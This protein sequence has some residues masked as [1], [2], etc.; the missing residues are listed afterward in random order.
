MKFNI[1]LSAFLMLSILT[2]AQSRTEELV[3]P[4][5][6]PN[7]TGTLIVNI[8]SGSI[9]VT[10]TNGKEVLLKATSG[11]VKE[12]DVRERIIVNSNV[13]SK[14]APRSEEEKDEATREAMKK[15]VKIGTTLSETKGLKR[16]LNSSMNITVTEQN[17]VV[18]VSNESPNRTVFLEIQVPKN[19]D[20]K[21][22]T[23][24]H[25]NVT[26]SD[27]NG[28]HE[29][30]NVNGS[31]ILENISG[32]A[33]A[34]TVNGKVKANLLEWNSRNPM[35]F[36]TLNGNV[37]LTLPANAK[38]NVKLDSDR[39]Q[40]YSDFDVNVVKPKVEPGKRSASGIY[41]V[42]VA[43]GVTGSVNGGGPEI[44]MKNMNG[45]IYLRKK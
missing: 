33:I 2:F 25:G 23:V 43:D 15:I 18:Q 17:N 4:L 39:G 6:K 10:G 35:A 42:T 26:V 14:P 7:E 27:V 1:L 32:S 31:I 19:F 24:N 41:K 38:F 28:N 29:I 8:V 40:I 20:L 13:N 22:S 30:G 34:N 44:M 45:N 11:D 16:L 9:K 3:I 12:R 21:L 5:T 37:D 36:S